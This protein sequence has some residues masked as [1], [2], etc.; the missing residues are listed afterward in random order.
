LKRKTNTLSETDR[1]ADDA[2]NQSHEEL[3][4]VIVRNVIQK[5]PEILFNIHKTAIG[6]KGEVE[7]LEIIHPV[8][9]S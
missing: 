1:L 6:A 2:Q 8:T 5:N 3:V 9:Y 4:S 7:C